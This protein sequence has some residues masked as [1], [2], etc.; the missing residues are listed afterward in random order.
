MSKLGAEHRNYQTRK[1]VMSF[2][3]VWHISFPVLLFV[4]IIEEVSLI[5]FCG[6]PV[7]RAAYVVVYGHVH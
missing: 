1:V 7:A 4:M 3:W 6:I 2:K 5:T